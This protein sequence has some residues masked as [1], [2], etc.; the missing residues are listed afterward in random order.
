MSDGA[1]EPPRRLRRDDDRDD[2]ESGASELDDWYR[3]FAWENQQANNAVTYVTTWQGATMG[4]Y[5]I[6]MA[7]YATTDLPEGLRKNRPSQT[8]CLLL[9]RLAVDLR[10]QKKGIGAALL[11]D[12]LERSFALSESVGAAALLIHCRDD[13][14]RDF[15]LANGDFIASPLEPMHLVLPMKEIRRRLRNPAL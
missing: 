3:R 11:R 5:A 1:L 7:G 13:R 6:A 15:Y 4:Y 8:P 12:A 14:A 9:A 10:A 2:F